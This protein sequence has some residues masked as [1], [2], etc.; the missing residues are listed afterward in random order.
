[1]TDDMLL[2]V[3]D[4]RSMRELMAC[5]LTTQG[6]RV[7][8]AADGYEALA[9]YWSYRE[10][11]RLVL[12]DM[13]MPKMTG[14][15]TLAE[16][17]KNNPLVRV[18]VTSGCPSEMFPALIGDPCVVGFV[19]KPFTAQVLLDSIQTALTDIHAAIQWIHT[20]HPSRFA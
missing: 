14:E 6:Y 3:D 7:L 15:E 1:M 19:S 17:K 20:P 12:L 13:V 11:I 9:R 5:I 16:M 2:V 4:D 10:Q 8:S 18:L